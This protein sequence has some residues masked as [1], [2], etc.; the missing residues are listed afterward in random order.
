MQCPTCGRALGYLPGPREVVVVEP[1][2]GAAFATPFLDAG[3]RWWRC[4]NASWGC[5]WLIPAGCG[6]T[7]CASCRLTRGRPDT[8]DVAAVQAWMDTEAAKRL[9]VF[10]L[11]ELGLP[12]VDRSADAPDGLAFDLVY[13]PGGTVQTGHLAGLVTIDLQEADDAYREHVRHDLGEP[14]RTM[15]GHLRHEIGHY[16]WP[17]LVAGAGWIDGFRELFGDER[18][19]YGGAIAQHP[20]RAPA[21]AWRDDHVSAYAS[22]HPWEDWAETF[23]HYIHIRDTIQTASAFGIRMTDPVVDGAA[24][25]VGPR[26]PP[27]APVETDFD[28]ILG[29]WLPLTHALNAVNRSMGQHDLYPFV[30]TPRVIRKLSFVHDRVSRR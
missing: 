10:Q 18:I 12:V 3:S 15:L 2:D 27:T 30:L 5:N 14:Y 4:L 1:V 9:L 24:V 28:A 6:E 17:S 16:Y 13:V 21:T 11:G 20:E 7:W 8:A 26:P 22:V 23:A 25:P 19:D 29:P